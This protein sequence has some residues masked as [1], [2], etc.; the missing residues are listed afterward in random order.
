M[1]R[2]LQLQSAMAP[3]RHA[4][5]DLQP[6][7]VKYSLPAEMMYTLHPENP[8]ECTVWHRRLPRNNVC[9]CEYALRGDA[10]KDSTY[11]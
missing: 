10:I 8:V 7:N 9:R 11:L 2:D 5:G 6:C 4:K 3:G 1:C